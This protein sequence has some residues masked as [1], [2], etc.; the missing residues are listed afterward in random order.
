MDQLYRR[1]YRRLLRFCEHRVADPH[2]AEEVAQEAFVQALRY[3]HSYDPA[4]PLWPWLRRIAER[5]AHQESRK[6]AFE[7]PAELDDDDLAFDARRPTADSADDRVLLRTALGRVP[8]RQQTA[9]SLRYLD[10]LPSGEAAAVLGLDGNAYD[11]LL[12]RA[13]QRL[14]AEFERLASDG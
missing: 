10:D 2:R 6:F 1:H 11:Q 14:I 8:R 7:S 9:L 12:W 4:R 13:R 3:F 5:V